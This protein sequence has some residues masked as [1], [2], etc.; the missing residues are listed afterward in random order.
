M[1]AEGAGI[2][3]ESDE[4]SIPMSTPMLDDD[5]EGIGDAVLTGP[6]REAEFEEVEEEAA[7]FVLD[8]ATTGA[9]L[10]GEG[11]DVA[12][13]ALDI[14]ASAEVGPDFN[15]AGRKMLVRGLG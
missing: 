6:V 1:G 12:E 10:A 5:E 14:F 4:S 11:E 2:A 3:L 9:G 8:A 15:E 13:G 7:V